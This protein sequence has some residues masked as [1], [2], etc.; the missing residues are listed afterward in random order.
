[1]S[2]DD[3]SDL[4]VINDDVRMSKSIF[5]IFQISTF[6]FLFQLQNINLSSFDAATSPQQLIDISN[7]KLE[8][9]T[10][11]D[12]IDLTEDC[13][14]KMPL[15]ETRIQINCKW[16]E[17]LCE[18]TKEIQSIQFFVPNTSARG[19][20]D[21]SD[22]IE[23]QDEEPTINSTLG[24]LCPASVET[25]CSKKA[26]IEKIVEKL[27]KRGN[28]INLSASPEKVNKLLNSSQFARASSEEATTSTK[29]IR[30]IRTYERIRHN[31]SSCSSFLKANSVDRS[32]DLDN[33]ESDGSINDDES[34][35]RFSPI[36]QKSLFSSLVSIYQ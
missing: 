13:S 33:F 14:P 1:L 4:E 6:Q 34:N 18:R 16:L 31:S 10:V 27:H 9:P 30:N 19:V 25:M 36:I 2:Q 8:K 21:D 12:S 11:V 20:D 17:S 3:D 24:D 32:K 35:T 22:V 23:I 29:L 15:D 5:K 7:I 26:D 28:L